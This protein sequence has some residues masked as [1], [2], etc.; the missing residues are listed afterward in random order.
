MDVSVII[1]NYNTLKMTKDCI[2]SV[3]E[4]TTDVEYEIILVDNAST[5]GSKEFFVNYRGITYIYN[6][7]NIGFGAANNVGMRIAR[8]ENILC[9]NSDTI[10][11]NNAI[12]Y[13]VN[14]ET[15]N[16]Q[17]VVLGSWLL[18][19][20]M[21]ITHSYG[22]FITFGQELRNA[23]RVFTD[24]IPLLNKIT[25][26]KEMYSYTPLKVDYIT[27]AD[28]FVPKNIINRVGMFDE[29]FFMYCEETDWQKRMEKEGVERVVINGP[30]IMH[31]EQGSQKL[32]TISFKK[33]PNKVIISTRST[34]FYLRKNN[35]VVVYE[36]FKSTYLFLRFFPMIFNEFPWK[37]KVRYFKVFFE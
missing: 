8:G 35:N 16:N 12:K 20:E 18:D 2:D 28:L 15:E 10:F 30:K 27:G 4:K 11:I 36:I 23:L 14:Y 37:D 32:D 3:I 17:N 31:L 19:Q 29:R 6:E 22:N 1:V 34:L 13:F 26:D 24:R 21:N 25:F 9:L 7:K 33:I 5:D